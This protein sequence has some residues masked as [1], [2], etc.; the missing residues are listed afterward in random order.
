MPINHEQIRVL[1]LALIK[2]Q[3]KFLAC[4]GIDKVKNI[5]HLRLLG[6]G[7]DFGENSVFALRR[8]LQEELGLQIK[9]PKL[10]NIEE[11]IFEFNGL[12]GHEIVFL[13]EVSFRSKSAY[14]ADGYNILD[15]NQGHRAEWFSV[16]DLS[17]RKL[18]P[19]SA[20]KYL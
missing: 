12:P 14:R 19:E 13:Y 4:A 18:Y 8:E 2:Y 1:S 10:L 3:G 5:Q 9:K 11:N 15:S 16:K 7:V 20:A 17:K 6:G